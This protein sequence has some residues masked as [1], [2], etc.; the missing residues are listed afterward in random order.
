MY[1]CMYVRMKYNFKII[2]RSRYKIRPRTLDG[3]IKDPEG[4]TQLICP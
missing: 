2:C 3:A 1:V 4:H